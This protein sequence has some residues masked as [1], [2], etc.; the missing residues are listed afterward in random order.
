MSIEKMSLVNLVGPIDHLNQALETCCQA[1]C[2]HPELYSQYTGGLEGI[3]LLQE[4]SPYKPLLKRITD[5]AANMKCRLYFEDFGRKASSREELEQEVTRLE[6]EYIKLINE[7]E[8]LSLLVTENE[9]ALTQ[10][11]HLRGLKSK[12]DDI[13]SCET[14]SVRFGLLPNE[15]FDKLDYY[16]EMPFFFFT[17]DTD[18]NYHWGFYFVPSVEKDEIDDVF[19]SLYFQRIRIPDYAHQTPDVAITNISRM[20]E[21]YKA[22][23]QATEQKL[24]AFIDESQIYLRQLF[25]QL[26]EYSDTFELRKYVLVKQNEFMLVGFVPKRQAEQFASSFDSVDGVECVLRGDDADPRL[27]PPVKLKNNWFVKPFEMFVEMYGL[28][29]YGT[30]DPTSLIAIVYCVL[31]GMMFGDLG[32]GLVISLLGVILWRKKKMRLGPILTRIGLFSAAFGLVYG[33]VFGLEDLLDPMYHALGFAEKPVHVFE[34]Q[35]TTMLL[36]LAIAIGV[37]LIVLA[38]IL[39]IIQ[40]IKERSWSRAVFSQNG[41][42]GLVLYVSVLGAVALLMLFNINVLNPVFILLAIVL[43][44]LL[45]FFREPLAK[46]VSRKK[47]KDEEKKSFGTIAIEGFFE[48]FENALNY[49]TNTISFVRVGGFILSHAGMMTVVL[50]LMNM[51][52]GVASPIVFVI[53]NLFV[54][55]LEGLIVGIQVLRLEYYEIFSRFYDGEGKPFEPAVISYKLED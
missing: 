38:I 51:V 13:F 23:L 32:Q 46:L 35:T 2:F 55:G 10:L 4:P 30:M 18:E 8:R 7:R 39:N 54:M 25:S 17:F 24:K 1:E 15:S 31:F 22:E 28:P 47:E 52:G 26:Q 9:Q 11:K 12:F 36:L 42:I 19:Q 41:V 37:G 44:L 34:P 16:E 48:L 21:D 45:L 27:T 53:G 49:I 3:T 6:D 14:V 43:P 50:T 33:S 29:S 40:G 20:L 5:L